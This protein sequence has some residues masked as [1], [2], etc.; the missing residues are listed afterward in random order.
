MGVRNQLHQDIPNDKDLEISVGN[1]YS[2][3]K[4][5]H[6]FLDNVYQEVR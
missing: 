4:L 2:K 6:T 1:S 3:D 5:M